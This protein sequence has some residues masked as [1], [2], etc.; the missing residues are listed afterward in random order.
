MNQKIIPYLWFD[1]QAIEA[2]EFYVNLFKNSEIIHKSSLEDTPSGSV[3]TVSFSLMGLM[4]NAMSAGPYFKI[5]PSISFFIVFESIEEVETIYNELLQGG[6]ALMEIGEYPFSQKYAWVQDRFG[7]NWQLM[8]T[9]DAQVQRVVPSLMFVNNNFLKV[10]EAI[11]FYL[12]V[13]ENSRKLEGHLSRYGEA[14]V[15][16]PEA[17]NYARIVLEGS[18]FIFMENDFKH[19]FNFNEAFSL[20]INCKTQD[21]IDY[22]WEK[23]S[24]VPESEQCGW[25]K[26]KY[27]VSW[28]IFPEIL[29]EM[30]S[31]GT[32][33]QI[34]KVTQSFLKMK[35]LDI[36]EL[37]KVFNS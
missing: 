35:K 34:Q 12:E 26:D 10:E 17:I 31:T 37:K 29:G 11:E 24:A 36:T 2:A 15:S 32:P 1:K 23:L 6:V 9:N 21:E 7:V 33:D 13:F 20:L 30:L 16:Y 27:G 14:S 4:V 28:Q 19:E 5:N 18:E 22:F 3:S 25:V 8:Y